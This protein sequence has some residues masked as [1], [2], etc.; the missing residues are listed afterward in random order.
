MNK[1]KYGSNNENK[2]MIKIG[3]NATIIIKPQMTT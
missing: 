3:S 2:A 1:V